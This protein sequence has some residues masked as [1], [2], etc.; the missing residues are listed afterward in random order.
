MRTILAVLASALV[1]TAAPAFAKPHGT[2]G[3]CPPD[4]GAA[5]AA[6]CPCD[7]DSQAQAWKNHGQYMKCVVHL[8]NELRKDGCLDDTAK[9]TI[10]SCAARSTCGKDGAV[11]CC[12]YDMSGTCNDP[13]PGDGTAAGTCSN[14]AT[15]ACDTSTD[16]VTATGPKVTRHDTTCTDRGGTVVGSGSACSTC[17]SPTPMPTATP[18]P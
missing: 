15:K 16:C 3:S 2:G 9:R 18:V 17:P 8:R 4:A 6:A 10:A 11:L 12:V 13:L 5:L 14:D 1:A 7:A